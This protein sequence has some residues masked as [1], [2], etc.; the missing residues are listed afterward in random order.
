VPS[1]D[2]HLD[3]I[4]AQRLPGAQLGPDGSFVPIFTAVSVGPEVS[5]YLVDAIDEAIALLREARPTA[6][7]DLQVRIDGFVKTV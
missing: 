1:D 3:A 6:P 4:R 5:H 7:P 2:L